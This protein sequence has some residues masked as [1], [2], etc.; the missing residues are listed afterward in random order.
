MP[1]RLIEMFKAQVKSSLGSAG[2]DVHR[3]VI[4]RPASASRPLGDLISFLEDTKERG[5]YPKVVADIGANQGNWTR[6]LL[7]IFPNAS[8]LMFEPVPAFAG[9]LKRISESQH[10]HYWGV[11]ISDSDGTLDLC[12]VTQNG[13]ATSGSTFLESSHAESYGLAKIP[14]QVRSLDSLVSS[15]E[16]PIPE[17]VKIDVEGFE[18]PVLRGAESLF[19]LTELFIIELSLYSFWQQPIFHE[20]VSWM[21]SRGYVLYDLAGF[22]R[23]PVD[24]ALGQVDACFVRSDST[25]R[26]AGGWDD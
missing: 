17:L 16:I 9:D 4:L 18:M 13:A 21:A 10:A 20:V 1:G 8:C 5:F 12:S 7:S 14:V 25:L 3:R 11:G 2:L 23:R 15:H 19:G 26:R 24:G 22:N 6:A